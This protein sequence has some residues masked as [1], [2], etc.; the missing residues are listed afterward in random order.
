MLQ[1]VEDL[2]AT[3]WFPLKVE[4]L[5]QP[6]ENW[7]SVCGT[8][9]ICRVAVREITAAS[10]GNDALERASVESCEGRFDR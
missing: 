1:G 4:L 7:L 2:D 9:L 5:L 8:G 3:M 10:F 6:Q